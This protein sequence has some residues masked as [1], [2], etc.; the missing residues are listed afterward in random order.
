MDGQFASLI[1]KIQ[2]IIADEG[3]SVKSSRRAELSIRPYEAQRAD[4]RNSIQ[5][6]QASMGTIAE[7]IEFL[8]RTGFKNES[9]VSMVHDI[10]SLIGSFETLLSIS[11]L[12][13]TFNAFPTAVVPALT[14][15]SDL[16][17]KFSDTLRDYRSLMIGYRLNQIGP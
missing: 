17:C 6:I 15:H 5:D 12:M 1:T 4:A 9:R 8:N 7:L 16:L 11:P 10:K 3:S 2:A 14:E 13:V